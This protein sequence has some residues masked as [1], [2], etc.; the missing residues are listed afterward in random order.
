M[1]ALLPHRLLCVATT[2]TAAA[3]PVVSTAAPP[4]ATASS[5]VVANSQ[6]APT[7]MSPQQELAP[8]PAPPSDR[9]ERM[10]RARFSGKRLIVEILAG[11]A[12]GSLVAYATF[13]SLCDGQSDCF[14]PALAGAGASFAVTPLAVWGTGRLMG[15]Q[16]GLGFT[17]L[18]ATAALAPFSATGPADESPSDTLS[19][20]NI[21]LAISTLLLPVTSAAFF[22]LS[23]HVRYARWRAAA[24]AGNLS[25]GITPIYDRHGVAGAMGRLTLSF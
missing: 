22:E 6:P 16:G 24:Q 1:R 7:L 8:T 17:Y 2:V 13:E 12:I 21:E 4:P 20:I 10:E 25:A 14:G 9:D 5:P 19:R 11:A 23:S 15:G 3:T 18:G